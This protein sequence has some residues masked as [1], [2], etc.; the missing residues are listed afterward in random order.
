M[1]RRREP[2]EPFVFWVDRCL[3]RSVPDALEAA[4]IDVRR[5]EDL[6]PNE[7]DVPDAEWIPEV[8]ERGWVIVTKDAAITRTR[9]EIEAL[10][11]AR[12]RFVCLAAKNMTGPE[13]VE[14]L[15]HHWRTVEG[16]LRTRRPPVLAKVLRSDVKWYDGKG[17]R[18]VK[19][20]PRQ[21]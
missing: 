5:Y 17:W 2:D 6:Y 18:R 19:R 4:K 8:A 1:T 16:L 21:G 7:P 12:A 13:Q 3:G 15:L 10:R 20:K 11:R 14:C 9:P